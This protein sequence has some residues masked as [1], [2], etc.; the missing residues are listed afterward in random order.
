MVSYDP[1]LVYEFADRFYRRAGHVVVSSV[2]VGLLAG[3]LVG[4]LLTEAFGG[5]TWAIAAVAGLIGYAAGSQRAFALKL[6]AQ[7]ALC[8][9]KIEE[10]TRA[11]A[12]MAE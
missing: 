2:V 6:Q 11:S 5:Y 1:K 7:Q 3:I 8:Q 12:G 9:V 10:N 4:R